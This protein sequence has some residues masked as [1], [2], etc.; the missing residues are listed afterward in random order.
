MP[1]ENKASASETWQRLQTDWDPAID[2]ARKCAEMYDP[3][4]FPP[5]GYDNASVLPAPVHTE[6]SY[7]LSNLAAKISFS[8]LPPGSANLR[9]KVNPARLRQIVQKKRKGV[10]E[11]DPEAAKLFE[12]ALSEIS[13]ELTFMVEALH[14]QIERSGILPVYQEAERFAL[15][16][17]VSYLHQCPE[18]KT[19][20]TYNLNQF[21]HVLDGMGQLVKLLIEE[22]FSWETLDEEARSVLLEAQKGP[23]ES[24]NPESTKGSELTEYCVYTCVELLP[25]Q[26]NGKKQYRVWQEVEELEFG[27][28]ATYSEDELPY[29]ALVSE[30]DSNKPYPVPRVQKYYG[31]SLSVETL[32]RSL[33]KAQIMAS[34]VIPLVDPA[35]LTAISDIQGTDSG[36]PKPGRGADVT[37]PDFSRVLRPEGALHLLE[38]HLQTLQRA[39]LTYSPRQGDRVTAEEIQ[40]WTQELMYGLAEVYSLRKYVVLPRIIKLFIKQLREEDPDSWPKSENGKETVEA[41]S[42]TMGLDA[43]GQ[44]QEIQNVSQ[45]IG[46]FGAYKQSQI[47]S[48]SDPRDAASYFGDITNTPVVRFLLNRSTIEQNQKAQ[49]EAAL[50]QK[51]APQAMSALGNMAAQQTQ[52]T[53][54]G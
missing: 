17:G 34:K 16:G 10:N 51:A 7:G 26:E 9:A 46:M 35:G 13:E 1:F 15:G 11:G 40:R 41:F 8:I 38:M 23:S 33:T 28:D 54:Q 4:A 2:L 3:Y 31:A 53:Q 5:D 32:Y 19:W 21:R 42:S 43:I 29:I 14:M 44:N 12:Q 45:F 30:Q 18:Y 25:L 37:A 22:K 20:R 52:P 39:Y 49:L 47:E 36:E 27:E 48:I 50:A 24:Q 6:T